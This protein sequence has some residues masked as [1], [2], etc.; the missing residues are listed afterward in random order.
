MIKVYIES[1][2]PFT[3][4]VKY[5]WHLF[6][7]NKH[8][9]YQW[10]SEKETADIV[11]GRETTA[12]IAIADDVHRLFAKG[13]F[14]QQEIFRTEPVIRH[15][16]GAPD[17]LSTCFYMINSLQEYG[18]GGKDEIG[19][20]QF[21]NSYQFR[22]GTIL[23]NTVQHYFNELAKHPKLKVPDTPKNTSSVFISH[24]IDNVSNAWIEDGFAALKAG[25]VHHIFR[26]LFHA[27]IQKP[28]WLNMDKIMAIHDEYS[29]NSTFFWLVN[30]GKVNKRMVNADYDVRSGKIKA[31]IKKVKDSGF[32]NGIH[33]SISPDS[34]KT[35][36]GKLEF[37]PIANRYHYLKFTLP[38]AY[39]E[40]ENSGIKLDSSLGFAEH[41]GFRNSW[42]QAFQPYNATRQKAFQVVEIPL[43]VMDRTFNNYMKTPVDKVS[44]LVISFFE[45]N[46]YNCTLSLL[47]HNNFFNSLKYK[48][49]TEEYKKI[50]AYLYENN[51]K[52]LRQ[53]E[54]IDKHLIFKA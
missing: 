20:F 33:K 21:K 28:D 13:I 48:G 4:A 10:V 7:H 45:Q 49:Y 41:Y 44:D 27:A 18:A 39:E 54:I 50:I 32:E 52:S 19:R 14:D 3:E 51:F 17:L 34:F 31:I 43:H 12:D 42:G 29:L 40:L 2:Q 46:R 22:F 30:K 23:Q 37:T 8:V 47:W 5:T 9:T 15:A 36:F 38:A 26:L 1:N 25:Q 53:Q 35:E 24:D 11:I 16:N 6:S